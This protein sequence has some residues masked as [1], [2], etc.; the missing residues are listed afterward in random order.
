MKLLWFR[1]SAPGVEDQY[2]YGTESEAAE[3]LRLIA[4]KF[5]EVPSN[6]V[7]PMTVDAAAFSLRK[8]LSAPRKEWYILPAQPLPRRNTGR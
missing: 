8:A 5:S 7:L 6:A 1:F 2:G 4:P 3:Y